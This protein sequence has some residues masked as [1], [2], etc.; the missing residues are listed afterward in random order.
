MRGIC[1]RNFS[2]CLKVC[3]DNKKRSCR[4]LRAQTVRTRN[5]QPNDNRKSMENANTLLRTIGKLLKRPKAAGRH[6]QWGVRV[7]RFCLGLLKLCLL[8]YPV[9]VCAFACRGA[10]WKLNPFNA[11]RDKPKVKQT[12][13]ATASES[14]QEWGLRRMGNANLMLRGRR[15]VERELQG[16]VFK[17]FALMNAVAHF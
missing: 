15:G 14:L 13:E 12:N 2:W 1:V 5:M 10:L 9:C 17:P 8:S 4:W 7:L 16:Q 6:R 3:N 11:Q